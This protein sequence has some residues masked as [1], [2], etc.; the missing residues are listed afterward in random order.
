MEVARLI[1]EPRILRRLE[2]ASTRGRGKGRATLRG[3]RG[4]TEGRLRGARCGGIGSCGGHSGAARFP[5]SRCRLK[6]APSEI[7]F[8]RYRDDAGVGTAGEIRASRHFGER[9]DVTVMERINSAVAGI[10]KKSRGA[11]HGLPPARRIEFV[12]IASK[13]RQRG[14]GGKHSSCYHESVR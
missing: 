11:R 5:E 7:R 14:I 2:S 8:A 4:E 13:R 12:L 10:N 9:N 1:N 3:E 6:D